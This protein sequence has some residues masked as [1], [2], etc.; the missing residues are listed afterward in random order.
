MAR[1]TRK[2]LFAL[3]IEAE[4]IDQVVE[5]LSVYMTEIKEERDLEAVRGIPM[6]FLPI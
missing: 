1:I 6:A 5:V 2:F 3:S 4:K